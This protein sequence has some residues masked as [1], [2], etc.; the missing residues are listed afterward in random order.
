MSKIKLGIVGFGF[1]GH[2]HEKMGRRVDGLAVN[3]ICDINP[4]QLEDAP[5]DIPAYTCVEDMLASADI[6]TILVACNNNQHFDV[7]AKAARAGKHIICEKPAAMTVEEFDKMMQLVEE[8]GVT[9]TVHQQ[10]R[11]DKDFQAVKAVYDENMVGD[12]Y[13]VQS[14][15][16]GYNGNMHD[17]HIYQS[18]G[19]GM[20]FDWGVHLIDQLLYM[21]DS[22]LKTIYA[23]MKNVINKEVDDFFKIQ[24]LFENGVSA[25]IELGTYFLT[26]RDNWFTR[27]WFLGGN[28]GSMYADG[29]DPQGKLVTTSH[30]LENVSSSKP[31]GAEG[32]TRSFGVPAEG[33]IVVKDIPRLDTY[34]DMFFENYV[35]ARA[36]QE[37]FL[38]KPYEVRRVLSVMEACRKSA[39][40]GQSIAFE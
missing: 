1:I 33:L 8:Y 7:V 38:V 13:T 2:E 18:E 28:K 22:P 39:K 10:R 23:Q 20:M 15:L 6:D 26:D 14:S 11:F 4:A 24:F 36:G 30:L 32:P 9:F 31:L 3:G 27:H 37:E 12:V 29:F 25:E 40:L 35:R 17:W 16:Y 21:I 34:Y 19:G 5:V